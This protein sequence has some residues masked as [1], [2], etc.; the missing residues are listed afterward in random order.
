MNANPNPLTHSNLKPVARLLV[1]SLLALAIVI[2]VTPLTITRP[3]AAQTLEERQIKIMRPYNHPVAI[4][5]IR[6]LQGRDFIRK[7][8]VEVQN[9]SNKPIYYVDL[10]LTFPD[11]EVRPR[12]HLGLSLVYGDIRLSHLTQPASPQDEFIPPGGTYVLKVILPECQGFEW[13][14]E[15]MNF[16]TAAT[17]HIEL[18][19]MEVSF[20]DGTGYSDDIEYNRR[21][22]LR[23]S[24]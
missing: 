17:N 2:S 14:R 18:R 5:E 8:E 3:A 19:F 12:T 16:P 6:N 20:G 13:H 10:D 24:S 1:P 11:I 21:R 23:K 22:S 9:V 7:L 15:D 4:K